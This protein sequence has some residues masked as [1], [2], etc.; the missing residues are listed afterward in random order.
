VIDKLKRHESR[1][2]K[3]STLEDKTLIGYMNLTEK[4]ITYNVKVD[5]ARTLDILDQTGFLHEIFYENLFYNK[6][7]TY[8]KTENKCKTKE[9]RP[10]AFNLLMIYLEAVEPKDL[11]D[12][13]E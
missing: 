4:L 10:A 3:T 9:A 5:K 7:K 1:E 13:C 6:D 8:S 11:A 2:K 12:F